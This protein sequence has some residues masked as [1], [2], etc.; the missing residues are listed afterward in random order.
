MLCP[1]KLG[2]HAPKLFQELEFCPNLMKL[3]KNYEK[4]S[5][6][7]PSRTENLVTEARGWLPLHQSKRANWEIGYFKNLVTLNDFELAVSRNIKLIKG[8]L[9][10]CVN[11]YSGFIFQGT[12]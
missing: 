4:G 6:E 2:G 10:I 3:C 5:V 9:I 11:T 12:S 7:S 8:M 1:S